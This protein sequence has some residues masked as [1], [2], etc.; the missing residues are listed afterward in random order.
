MNENAIVIAKYGR[1]N[2]TT[3]QFLVSLEIFDPMMDRIVY[4]DEPD[5]LTAD[6]FA[7]QR[8][9]AMASQA[10]LLNEK[11]TER[12]TFLKLQFSIKMGLINLNFAQGEV[13]RKKELVS[14]STYILD[15]FIKNLVDNDMKADADH[16]IN[17]WEVDDQ[18]DE[19]PEYYDEPYDDP[20]DMP[21][22]PYS[23]LSPEEHGY[24][25]ACM[26]NPCMCSDP[27]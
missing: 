13:I 21:Y 20:P 6:L 4:D 5:N 8:M 22:D 24:C 12:H 23:G 7:K 26:E 3:E 15:Q 18:Y 17:D 11:I 14:Y 16:I 9:E 1:F 19:A 10:E 2:D 25:A 27:W